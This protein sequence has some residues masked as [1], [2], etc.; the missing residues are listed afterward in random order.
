MFV[1]LLNGVVVW[2]GHV[3]DNGACSNQSGGY[4]GIEEVRNNLQ[5]EISCDKSPF[6]F[7]AVSQY[8]IEFVDPR[9]GF[10]TFSAD[11]IEDDEVIIAEVLR[12]GV[13]T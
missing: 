7:G 5:G 10:I 4:P 9:A 2:Y 6:C 8:G 3:D 13:I 11:I 1:L 12:A